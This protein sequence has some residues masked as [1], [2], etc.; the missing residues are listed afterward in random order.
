MQKAVEGLNV[1]QT[2]DFV[3]VDGLPNPQIQL[4]SPRLLLKVTIK[5]FLSQQPLSL[6]KFIR[7][8]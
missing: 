7:T 3:L 1:R 5:V 6:R 4:P 2:A 8:T